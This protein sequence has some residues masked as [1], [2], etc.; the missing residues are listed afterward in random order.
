MYREALSPKNSKKIVKILV[1]LGGETN[2]KQIQE[3]CDIPGATIIYHLNRLMSFGVIENP[4]K[5]VYRIKYKSPLSYISDES[6]SN[7]TYF[8][9]LG[10][11]E[12]RQNPEPNQAIELLK[13]EDICVETS[14]VVTT[15]EALNEWK[16][17][18]LSFN[19]ILCYSEEIRDINKVYNKVKPILELQMRISLVVLD[20]TSATKPA[21]LAYYKLA[22]EYLLPLIYLNE[23]KQE[24]I[25]LNSK[26]DIKNKLFIDLTS[27]KI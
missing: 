6:S 18:Q 26:E 22:Q 4:L 16:Q 5:G 17:S 12:E 14:Y 27:V 8:G 19:W 13:R 3:N 2:Y 23:E 11:K 7:Y 25:W 24:L 20:C 1:E 15:L 10:R 21:T 9:L